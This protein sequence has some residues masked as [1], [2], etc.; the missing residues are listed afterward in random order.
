MS[1]FSFGPEQ[2]WVLPPL[3]LHPFSH[4]ADQRRLLEGSKAGLIQNGLLPR[5]RHDVDALDRK[6]LAGRYCELGMLH[7][8]GSDLTCWIG[9]CADMANRDQALAGAGVQARSFASLL[10]ED[11]PAALASKARSWGVNDHA[12]LFSRA[13][14]VH[15]LF[16]RM[17]A[18]E[19]LASNFVRDYQRFADRFFACWLEQ[20]PFP[21]IHPANFDFQ[22]YT[23]AEYS[24]VLERE[25][26]LL[27]K[28]A[29]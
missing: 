29:G 8:I 3:V 17:P 21:R 22:M 13:L 24:G 26:G 11:P 27:A 19:D 5:G 12:S 23:S 7:H 14:G 2:R 25:S 18:F 4:S 1:G 28:A 15:S 20:E 9:L 6:L 10:V 16:E